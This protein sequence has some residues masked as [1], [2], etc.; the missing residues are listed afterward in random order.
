MGQY[1]PPPFGIL[2]LAA[3]LEKNCEEL[4]IDII[5]S[6]ADGLDWNALENR[7]K[8]V[9]PDIVAPSALTTCNAFATARVAQIAKKINSTIKTIVGGQHF[10]ALAEDSMEKYPEIDYIIRGEG[11]ETLR[12]LVDAINRNE[13]TK[14]ILGLTQ[15]IKNSIVSTPDRP[16]ICDLNSLP[17]P[18]YNFVK[19]HM[20]GYYFS[21]MAEKETSFAIIEGSR[22]CSHNCTY[23]TQSPFWRRTHRQKS[24]NRIVDEIEQ[25][26]NEYGSTFFWFTDDYFTLDERTNKICELIIEKKLDI[27]W[28]CQARCDDIVQ[29]KELIPKL[30]K[31]GNIWMLLGFDTPNPETLKEFRRTGINKS[32]AKETVTTLR[33][34]QIFSQGTFIIGNRSDTKESIQVL[35]EYADWLDPDL[36]TFMA[37]TPYPG[38]EIFEQAKQNNWIEDYNWANYDMI[39]AIM[40]TE[41]LTRNEVQEELYRCYDN[42]FGSWPRRYKGISSENKYVRRTYQYLAKQALITRLQ[43][44]F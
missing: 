3:Y 9:N 18:G 25:I 32:V 27:S 4:N 40:P 37:L 10:T 8:T 12:E 23:C 7:I 14:N 16:L 11:E 20:K 19:K 28:F 21:L 31:S 36:A 42:F 1:I 35:R 22:G 33:Q 26:Y 30:S 6:Q 5:D 39:H 43:N 41:T 29:N 34:N 44:L 13:N 2:T 15:R 24:P 38:T 17:H